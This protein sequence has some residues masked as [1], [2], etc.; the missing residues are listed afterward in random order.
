MMPGQLLIRLALG[1]NRFQA[2]KWREATAYLQELAGHAD[3][4]QVPA[5]G[6]RGAGPRRRGRGAAQASRARGAAV[7][8]GPA[9]GAGP[10]PLAAG[11]GR[12]GPGAGRADPGRALPAPAGRGLGRPGRAGPPVRAAGR[13]AA[14]PGATTRGACGPTR[15]RWRCSTRPARAT[16]P[17]STRPWPCQ[18]A[19]GAAKA[20]AATTQRLLTLLQDPKE[21]AA[22]RR[23]AALL[24]EAQGE[25][26]QAGELL[27]QALAENP[28]DEA[29]L[30]SVVAAYERAKRRNE[31]EQVLSSTLPYL[32]PVADDPR[33]RSRRAGLW[34][35]LGELRR[36]QPRHQERHRGG[37]ERGG[38]RARPGQRPGA[39]GQPLRRQEPT[40]PRRP[41]ATAASWCARDVTHAE[42]LRTLARA[43]AG[44]GRIDWAR[45]FFEVL[46]LF[47]LTEK[48]DRAFL[49]AHPPPVRKP[50][51]PYAA[52]IED[53][54]G[55]RYLAHPEARGMSEVFAAIWEGVPGLGGPTVESL[56]LTPLDKVSPISDVAIG[57]IFGQV[58]Q[59]PRQPAGEP[60]RQPPGRRR[61][62]QHGGAG[63]ARHRRRPAAGR[64]ATPASC[65][66]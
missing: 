27:E 9:A 17:C 13:R 1:E 42:S 19:A 2:K 52:T 48:K 50:E 51:D 30:A 12:A 43:Y 49:A 23:E 20:A 54:D 32:E 58:G 47:G 55:R 39:A 41:C 38:H 31:L 40:T 26:G 53:A 21:R 29:V 24:L 46:E 15:T 33:A 5:G 11:D 4:A 34:E 60:V 37:G 7:P 14:Q 61:R 35:K 64:A 62:P 16:F 66:S 18:R 10:P 63:A 8:G 44:Q 57:Q 45:C 59:G 22:R 28:K 6:G 25:H 3:A 36:K 65:A 56:G